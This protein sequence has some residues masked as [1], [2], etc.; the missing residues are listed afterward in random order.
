MDE[1]G[2]FQFGRMKDIDP[3]LVLEQLLDPKVARHLPLLPPNPD[4]A[5]A[6]QIIAMKEEGWERDGLAHWAITCG[7]EYVGWG[8]FEKLDDEW[9][10]G[11]VLR[12]SYF[13]QGQAIARQAFD[14]ARKHTDIAEITF[15][16]P[17]SRSERVLIRLG[18]R[19]VGVTDYSGTPF[20]KWAYALDLSGDS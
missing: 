10:F 3:Q 11:L 1:A 13:R 20:R 15:L 14:W 12:S 9:D 5:L 16:L 8:G 19:P 7:G 4:L 6:R 2:L 18:A 17:L